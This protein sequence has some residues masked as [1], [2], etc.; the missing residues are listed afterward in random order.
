MMNQDVYPA[1]SEAV[2]AALPT[3]ATRVSMNGNHTIFFNPEDARIG[4]RRQP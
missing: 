1:Q 2:L 3:R 4:A